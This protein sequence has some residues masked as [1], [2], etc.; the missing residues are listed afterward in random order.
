M[1]ARALL[2][3]ELADGRVVAERREQLDVVLPDVEEHGV[4]ALLGDRLP[5]HE[6]H[7]EV[8][9]VERDRGVDVGDRDADVVNAAEHRPRV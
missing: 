3:E 4:D 8:A 2:G 6:G 9:L 1:Q 5:V 7:G